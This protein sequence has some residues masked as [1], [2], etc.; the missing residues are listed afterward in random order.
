MYDEAIGIT[1][2]VKINTTLTLL[3]FRCCN[4][5]DDGAKAIAE[6]LETNTTIQIIT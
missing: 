1:E 5:G 2:A 4:I 3:D 6:A